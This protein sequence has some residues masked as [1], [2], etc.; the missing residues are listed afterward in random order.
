MKLEILFLVMIVVINFISGCTQ[1]SSF[2]ATNKLDIIQYPEKY[3]N[4][5]VTIIM[6]PFPNLMMAYYPDIKYEITERDEEGKP[7]SMMVKYDT[8]Y[9]AKC[10]I[11]GIVKSFKACNCQ[12]RTFVAGAPAYSS[13]EEV[14]WGMYDPLNSIISTNRCEK[15]PEEIKFGL[16][17]EKTEYRCEPNSER[18]IYY[19]D[20]TKVKSLD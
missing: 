11:T 19:F 8:F 14:P 3:Y 4:R 13:I 6:S 20:V 9:C 15:E 10:E 16:H 2:S 1:L 12:K 18:D 7:I 17:Y 5:T